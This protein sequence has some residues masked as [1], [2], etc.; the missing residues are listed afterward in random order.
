[1]AI[2]QSEWASGVKALC[3]SGEAGTVVANRFKVDIATLPTLTAGDILEIGGIPAHHEVIDWTLDNDALGAGTDV[4]VGVMSGDYGSTD[5]A[6]TAGNE[7]FDASVALATAGVA[8]GDRPEGFRIAKSDKD[9][10]IGVLVN[11]AP[12]TQ[13]SSG[14]IIMTVLMAQ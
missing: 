6:R 5:V 12:G 7:F 10:G 2:V 4:D 3:V 1:M 14:Y 9:R 8:R 13:A 11:T